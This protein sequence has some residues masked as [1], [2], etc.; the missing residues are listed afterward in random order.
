VQAL[1]E[2]IDRLPPIIV[3][4]LDIEAVRQEAAALLEQA[5]S[6]ADRVVAESL[7]RRA[8]ALGRRASANERSAQLVRRTAALRAEIAAEIEALREGLATFHTGTTDSGEMAH[9]SES[10]RR[11]AAEAIAV[12]TAREE[13]DGSQP[14]SREPVQPEAPAGAAAERVGVRRL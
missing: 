2:A 13:L 12:A 7:A 8:D 4:P 10:A 3:A 9:L 1:G 6:E 11:V 5:R 14:L